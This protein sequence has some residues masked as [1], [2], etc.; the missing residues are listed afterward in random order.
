MKQQVEE[1]FGNLEK[2]REELITLRGIILACG[3]EEEL[4]WGS[5]C[6]TSG[7]ANVVMLGGLKGACVLSFFK[8]SLLA[9]PIGILKKPG[10]NSQAVRVVKF[11]SVD[12]ITAAE[13]DLKGYIFKAVEIEKVGMKV[14]YKNDSEIELLEELRKKFKED[15]ELRVAFESLTPGR[16]RAYNMHFSAAKQSA[17]RMARI[18]K[19]APRI[20]CGK[21]LNDCTCGLS[22]R[23]PGCDGSHKFAV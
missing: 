2:W 10:E 17:T 15:S 13:E 5:P 1:Y 19:C 11:V 23:M 4:K 8:G 7:G 9:D 21:G 6:Y 18:E 16:Q 14:A 22:K 12:E 3:L 20:L